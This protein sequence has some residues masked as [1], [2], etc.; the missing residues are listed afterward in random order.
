MSVRKTEAF[1]VRMTPE[2]RQRLSAIAE[3]SGRSEGDV[4]RILLSL[5]R[6]EHVSIGIDLP[7]VSVRRESVPPTLQAA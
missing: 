6:P 2:D 7:G 4:I 1:M 5:A 3:L